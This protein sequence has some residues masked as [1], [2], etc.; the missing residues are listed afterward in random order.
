MYRG[1]RGSRALDRLLA[2]WGEVVEQRAVDGCVSEHTFKGGAGDP[3]LARDGREFGYWAVADG[4]LQPLA[5]LDSAEDGGGVIAEIACG[6][7]SHAQIVA[8]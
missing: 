7:L 1:R 6:D 3:S 2:H 8:P 5:R 4:H